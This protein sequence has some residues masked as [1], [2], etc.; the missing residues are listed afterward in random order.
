MKKNIEQLERAK[1]LRFNNHWTLQQIGNELGITRQR[2][3]QLLGNT[4]DRIDFSYDEL[5]KYINY[6]NKEIAD[7]FKVSELTISKATNR[8]NIRNKIDSNFGHGK[9]YKAENLVIEKLES[10]GFK[11]I[12][13]FPSTVPYNL[14]ING[15]KIKNSKFLYSKEI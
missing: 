11:D 14:I 15:L 10:L 9:N 1:G 13:R 8:L 7:I 2:V 3:H 6:T 12:K 4:G 5:I